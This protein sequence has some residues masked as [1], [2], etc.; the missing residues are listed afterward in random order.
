[1]TDDTST[2]DA[3][4]FPWGKRECRRHGE[5]CAGERMCPDCYDNLRCMNDDRVGVYPSLHT[6]T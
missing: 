3:E 5:Y 4:H 2:T 1:M 6:G